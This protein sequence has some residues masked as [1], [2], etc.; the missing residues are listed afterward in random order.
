MS[1]PVGLDNERYLGEQTA[2]I[3]ERVGRF[4]NKLYLEFGGKLLWDYHAARVL[5]GFDPNVKMR[6]LQKLAEASRSTRTGSPRGTPRTWT[7]SC[8]TRGT[9]P[10]SRTSPAAT[11]SWIDPY[12]AG[13]RASIRPR[14]LRSWPA[15]VSTRTR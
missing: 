11:S 12:G 5:S 8:P 4:Q 7:S 10:T 9:E 1:T 3:L 2:A 14:W 15:M 6:L 13:R